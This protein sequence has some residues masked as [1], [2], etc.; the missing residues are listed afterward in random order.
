VATWCGRWRI[1]RLPSHPDR[2]GGPAKPPRAGVRRPNP[3]TPVVV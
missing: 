1:P 2:D 3:H